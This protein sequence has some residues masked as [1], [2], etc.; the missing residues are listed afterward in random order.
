MTRS[1]SGP[2]F[3]LD[4]RQRVITWS[5]QGQDLLGFR[6]AEVL[7]R[8]CYDLFLCRD[9]QGHAVGCRS[10][11]IFTSA[12]KGRL[13]Q[14]P[15]LLRRKDGRWAPFLAALTSASVESGAVV[16]L[17]PT[18]SLDLPTLEMVTG[19]V[20]RSTNLDQTLNGILDQT[21]ALTGADAAEIFV[22]DGAYGQLSMA[23]CRGLYAG[24]FT[25]ITSFQEGEGFPGI[26]ATEASPLVSTSLE[27]DARYLRTSVKEKGVHYYLCLPLLS[28]S[29]AFGC[30]NIASRSL[31]KNGQ[32]LLPIL[33]P[34]AHMAS[35]AV[36]VT[37]L[38]ALDV[39]SPWEI[40]WPAKTQQG[41][42]PI[43]RHI[44]QSMVSIEGA[45]GGAIGLWDPALRSLRTR[46]AL[47][48]FQQQLCHPLT[49]PALEKGKPVITQRESEEDVQCWRGMRGV[50]QTLCL[51]LLRGREKVGVISLGSRRTPEL[52]SRH[53]GLLCS[54]ATRAVQA[55]KLAQERGVESRRAEPAAARVVSTVEP[56]SGTKVPSL[57]LRCFGA[58]Q[59]VRNGALLPRSAFP[60][61]K[62]ITALKILVTRRGRP[63]S[64]D[65]L[66]EALWPEADPKAA[67]TGLQVIIHSLRRSLETPGNGS[68][69]EQHIQ[70]EGNSYCFNTRS[71]YRLDVD[72]FL[73]RLQ[74]ARRLELRGELEAALRSYRDAA[75]LYAGDFLEDEPYSDW[76]SAE[77]ETLRETHFSALKTIARLLLDRGDL[78]GSIHYHRQAL[79]VDNV[80]EETHRELMRT[81]WQ[82]GRRDEA[83][84]QYLACRSALERELGVSPL[85]ETEKLYRSVLA[86]GLAGAPD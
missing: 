70:T 63:V 10:C 77:R 82:A 14:H 23:A 45:D 33:W 52:P 61:R 42:D 44:L 22:A 49:C 81:L 65:F 80:R 26:V 28:E 6:E 73:E 16:F 38:R 67:Q 55:I 8:P 17:Q 53:L 75:Q 25:Q 1:S 59:V 74:R 2:A 19:A 7:G 48:I 3:V 47:G 24:A 84:R 37:R 27:T 79:A 40:A 18:A 71:S 41:L 69:T 32:S 9:W 13:G 31:P 62:A 29:G 11:A 30:L 4:H 56:S 15:L 46:V 64:N 68:G 12:L 43:L 21:L 35:T 72:E 66:I 36:Q 86:S 85:P 50:A 60:R 54:M 20:A 34:M 39:V 76:C 78:E 51:P 57:E 58:F 83:L 5:R